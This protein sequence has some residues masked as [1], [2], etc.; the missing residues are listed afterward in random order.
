MPLS[1]FTPQ[2]REWFTRAFAEPTAAQS[3]AWPAIATGQHA[4][5]SAP[6]GSGKTRAAFVWALGR[7]V[8]EPTGEDKRTRL[9]YVSPL[10]A[11]SYDIEKNLRAPLR[12]I[13]G[14]IHDGGRPRGHPP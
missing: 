11:L 7:W 14:G 8:P 5:I 9:V 13:G 2:V 6:T 4:L 1:A 3:Q 12:G 10:K